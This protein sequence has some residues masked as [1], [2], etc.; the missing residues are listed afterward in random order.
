MQKIDLTGLDASFYYEKLENGLDCYLIP[1]DNKNSYFMTYATRYGS[2]QTEF[3]PIGETKM[4]H[5][6]DGIA[7]FLEHKMFEQ[8]DGMDPFTFYAKTGTGANA[9]TSFESTQYICYGTQNILENL[10]YLLNY[11]NEPYFTDE[12]VQKEKGIIAEEIKMYDDIPEWELEEQLRKSVYHVHPMRV[13]IAGTVEEINKITKEDLYACY[14]TFY[15]P[16]NMFLIVAGSFDKDKVIECIKNNKSMKKTRKQSPIKVKEYDE[17]NTVNE[18]KKQVT[19]NIVVPKLGYALKFDRTKIKIKDDFLL[20]LYLQMFSTIVLGMSSKFREEARTK[21]LMTSFYTSWERIDA[22]KTSK[23]CTLLIMAET[24]KP[25]DLLKAIKEELKDITINEEDVE[26]MKKVWISSEVQMIDIVENTVNNMYDDILKYK[27]PIATKVDII[28]K[29]NAKDLNQL[30]KELD[31]N[32]S[33]EI[34]MY[35]K[36]EESIGI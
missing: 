1:Y 16:S 23:Y 28:K 4:H 36:T 19:M 6:P 12:N 31:F 34:I 30:I 29:L 13:D 26:R 33:A 20:D 25:D 9:S 21:E 22:S 2:N 5:V 8:E 3:V 24:T 11:V 35:P 7:H 10:D 32:N 17:K 14:N 27:K 15:Q 18:K